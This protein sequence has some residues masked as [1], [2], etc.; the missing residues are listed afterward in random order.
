M[1]QIAP[2]LGIQGMLVDFFR[3]NRGRISGAFEASPS[4]VAD[5]G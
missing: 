5:M 2:R 3:S 1:P 4:K